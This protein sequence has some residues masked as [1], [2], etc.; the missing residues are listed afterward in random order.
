M[1]PI[2]TVRVWRE[3]ENPDP[4]RRERFPRVW[5]GA[6]ACGHSVNIGAGPK[7]TIPQMRC[8]ECPAIE[9]EVA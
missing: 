7:P 2:V 5:I 9:S 1:K 6:L 8:A 4:D 3:T